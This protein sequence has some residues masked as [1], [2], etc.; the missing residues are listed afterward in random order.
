MVTIARV[1]CGGRHT[2]SYHSE[3]RAQHDDKA[4]NMDAM[5]AGAQQAGA[6]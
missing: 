5:V 6:V 4:M 3:V 2:T 1:Q